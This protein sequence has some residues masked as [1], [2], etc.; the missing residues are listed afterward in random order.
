VATLVLIGVFG[1]TIG[2]TTNSFLLVTGTALSLVALT[3]LYLLGNLDHLL[4]RERLLSN[5]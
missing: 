5:A 1:A 2:I 4:R 3:V